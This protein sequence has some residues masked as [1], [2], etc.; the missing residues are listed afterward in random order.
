[1]A[2]SHDATGPAFRS[3]IATAAPLRARSMMNRT[4]TVKTAVAVLTAPSATMNSRRDSGDASE[5]CP[6]ER[7]WARAVAAPEL[8]PGSQETRAPAM[9]PERIPRARPRRRTPGERE[10]SCGGTAARFRELSTRV[11]RPKSPVNSGNRT[12][13][14]KSADQRPSGYQFQ[15]VSHVVSSSTHPKAPETRNTAAAIPRWRQQEDRARDARRSFSERISRRAIPRR[16]NAI[17][18]FAR[19][20]ASNGVPRNNRRGRSKATEAAT[21]ARAPLAARRTAT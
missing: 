3:R 16:M 19:S 4:L 1:M 9:E 6:R 13:V 8:R 20:Y 7:T 10:R 12:R 21:P 14:P 5:P 11:E 2:G 17:A 18:P 15:E